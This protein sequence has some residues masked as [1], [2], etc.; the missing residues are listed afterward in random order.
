L[1]SIVLA[2]GAGLT[3]ADEQVQRREMLGLHEKWMGD[4]DGMVER[5][6][7]R[8]LV[9]F[10]KMFYFL[11]GPTQRGVAYELLKEFETFVN[12]RLKTRTLKINMIFIP[13]GRD[14]LLPALRDGRGDI[15]AANLTI[16]KDRQKIVAFSDPFL[17]NVSEVLVTGPTAPKVSVVDDLS[18]KEI[19]VR[20][21]AS[22]FE[23]L[24]RLNTSFRQR[25]RPEVKIIPAEEYL[26]DGDLLEMVNASL[27]PMVIVDSHKAQ[28]WQDIFGDITVHPEIAINTGGHIAWAFRKQSPKLEAMANEFIKGHKKGTLLGNILYKRY[29]RNNKWVSNSLTDNDLRRFKDM[30]SLFKKYQI[31]PSTAAD[32]NVNI[33]NIEQLENNIHAGAKYMRFLHERYFANGELDELNRHLFAF[34]AYNA[35]PARVAKLRREATALGLNPNEW[36]DNVEIV[37]AKRIGRETVQYVSNI[38]KYYVAYRLV[39]D[40]LKLRGDAGVSQK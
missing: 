31:L 30:L 5:R 20:P 28:F 13:V 24:T 26:E 33:P 9:T 17:K 21:S 10:N 19:H 14:E 32:R 2:T 7:I 39:A 12:K 38:Y 35:G 15:A 16:T 1:L 29:L 11:D 25:G 22:Y 6:K 37:A 4:F 3:A 27:I 18:G 40:R 8:A 36:F 34:A 23:S